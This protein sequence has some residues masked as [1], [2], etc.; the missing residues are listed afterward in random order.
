MILEGTKSEVLNRIADRV[1]DGCFF[2]I[3]FV[4]RT[5][6]ELRSMTARRGVSKGVKGVGLKYSPSDKGL[7][8]VFDVNKIDPKTPTADLEVIRQ[9]GYTIEQLQA[10]DEDEL[11]NLPNDVKNAIR[12]AYRMVPVDGILNI[13]IKGVD[14]T[15]VCHE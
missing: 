2:S 3:S 11:N 14:Y 10:M 5:T 15:V 9:A 12:G 7:L 13:R 4:K 6:G 1:S 8:V